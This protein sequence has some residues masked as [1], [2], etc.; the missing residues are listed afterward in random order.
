MS[1]KYLEEGN[2]A[3][4]ARLSLLYYD[5]AYDF[6]YKNNKEQKIIELD[7]DSIDAKINTAKVQQVIEIL[8]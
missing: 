8:K 7:S 2:L 4:V 5:K 6:K 3:D 1:P